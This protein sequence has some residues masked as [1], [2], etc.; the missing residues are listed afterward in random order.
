MVANMESRQLRREE[1][2]TQQLSPEHPRASATDDVEGMF[3]LLHEILGNTFDL[4]QFHDAQ[5]KI[6]NEFSKRIDPD[7]KFYYWTGA[8]HR[9]NEFDL[10]SFNGPTKE[11][12]IE[13][14]DRVKLSR[15]GDPGVFVANRAS[16]PQKGQL[17]ARAKFHQ[18]PVELPPHIID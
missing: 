9:Y 18:A 13:R 16:L 4:K 6:L 8:K 17:T 7:L 1:Y 11:G 14:L 10:P 15:R 5:A 12:A 3:S 2:L